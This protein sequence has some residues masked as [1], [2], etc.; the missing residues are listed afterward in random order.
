MTNKEYETVSTVMRVLAKTLGIAP[1][2]YAITINSVN[3]PYINAS[4][5][6][7]DYVICGEELTGIFT[8]NAMYM[9]EHY[10]TEER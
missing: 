9:P 1:S 10:E 5:R 8:D 3:G 7:T 6:C 4:V 2:R